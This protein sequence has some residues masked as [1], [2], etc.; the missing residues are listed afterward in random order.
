MSR[1]TSCHICQKTF[2][3]DRLISGKVIRQGLTDL[4]KRDHPEWTEDCFICDEDF[5]RYRH[6]YVREMLEADKGELTKLETEVL[7][8]IKKQEI[9][10]QNINTMMR[11]KLTFGQRLADNIAKFGGSWTFII[12]F[13]VVILGWITLNIVALRRPFDP[14]PFILLNLVLSCLAALQAPVIM[15][16]QNR[17]A[18]KDRFQ[19]ESDY[20]TNLKAELE[21]R[22]LHEKLD[23][24]LTHQWQRLLEIQELQLELMEKLSSTTTKQKK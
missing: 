14:Y 10:S 12:S 15:M 19:A 6:T 20:R 8:S 18:Q 9:L 21:I 24:L 16:S 22:L 1:S 2:S 23:H 11:E 7:E 17:Q 4:I 13:G 3:P 5:N